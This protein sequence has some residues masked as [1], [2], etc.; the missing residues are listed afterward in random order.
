M[1]A[2]QSATVPQGLTFYDC[3]DIVY[4]VPTGRAAGEV[5]FLVIDLIDGYTTPS[6]SGVYAYAAAS[7]TPP[8]PPTCKA[9]QNVPAGTQV[10]FY[11]A[12]NPVGPH[13]GDMCFQGCEVAMVVGIGSASSLSGTYDLTGSVCAAS[14]TSKNSSPIT[15]PSEVT[16]PDGSKTFCDPI[17][18]KCVTSKD[19]SNAPPAP[20]SSSGNNSTDSNSNTNTTPAGSSSS[21]GS[22]DGSSGPGTGTGSTGS[23]STGGPASSSSTSTK[24]TTGVCDVGEADGT[25]GQL[26]TASGDTPGSV[27]SQFKS[28]VSNAPIMTAAT[29]FFTV[30][31]A[32]SCPTWHIPGNKYW[33]A[34]GFDFNFFCQPAILEI[35]T[36]AGFIVLAVGAFCAFRI[37]IY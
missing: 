35:L 37:A 14:G 12:A 27:F 20:S 9:G 10:D 26:Y 18:G 1:A 4:S 19:G 13:D 22:G 15:K 5:D 30:D 25:V 11:Q 24:C 7:V 6:L 16:N 28:D 32:G 3:K 31:A 36:W 8:P 2:C 17:S 29:G 34:A 23:G 21:G 33:G